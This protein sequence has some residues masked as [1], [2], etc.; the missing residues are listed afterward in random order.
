[1]SGDNQITNT[2]TY[3]LLLV[4][5]SCVGKTSLL[6][7]FKDRVFLR[8]SYI[9]TIGI[10]YKTRIVTVN[11]LPVRLQIWD[12]AGQEKF[13]SL[14]KTYY[15]DSHAVILV[16][17]I[18]REDTLAHTKSWLDEINSNILSN[19]I[20]VLVGNKSDEERH[21]RV[22]KKDGERVA[23]DSGVLYWET[24][25]KS[26]ANVDELFHSLAERLI[27]VKQPN[28]PQQTN[29]VYLASG[30]QAASDASYN[31][32]TSKHTFPFDYR[33]CR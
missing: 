10:D 3:K 27:G 4:G 20:I 31:R 5:D 24:S 13:R 23:K 11:G 12:T 26:G 29:T 17:D 33:C 18:T 2:P 7:R 19:T 28:S 25:A 14:T 8:G 21:R 16:Y 9:A 1:M 22:S 6:I 32:S 30:S 15:R